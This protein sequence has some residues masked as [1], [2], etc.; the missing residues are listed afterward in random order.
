MASEDTEMVTGP[1]GEGTSAGASASAG[2]KRPKRFE[3][4]KWNAVALWA[5]GMRLLLVPIVL[6]LGMQSE[7]RNLLVYEN[8]IGQRERERF[9]FFP[10]ESVLTEKRYQ[11]KGCTARQV[12]VLGLLVVEFLLLG[13]WRF[14]YS[15]R[16]V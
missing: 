1:S 6:F 12:L 16:P 4:K 5:W 13:L 7:R 3:I 15:I 9:F 10:T 8:K 14:V 11:K 2:S